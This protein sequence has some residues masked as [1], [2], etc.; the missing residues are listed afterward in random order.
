MERCHTPKT[1]DPKSLTRADMAFILCTLGFVVVPI[2]PGTKRPA[3]KWRSGQGGRLLSRR[4]V[5]R[6][7]RKHPDH[8]VAIVVGSRLIMLDAD[9]PEAEARLHEIEEAHD[10]E[11]NL[12]IRTARGVHHYLRL[13]KG[14]VATMDG[15]DSKTNP[16]AIDI[17]TGESLAI[18]PPSTGKSFE[19][20]EALSVE[21]LP[22]ASQAF[23][24]A[25]ERNNRPPPPLVPTPPPPKQTLPHITFPG[26]NL[27]LIASQ[28]AALDPD[29]GY[30]DWIK[31]GMAIH[32]ETQ[33]SAE[34]LQLFNDWSARGTKYR[35]WA[36]IEEKWGYM[37]TNRNEPITLGTLIFMAQAAD[38][39]LA[40]PAPVVKHGS[41]SPK[42]HALLP[43]SLR[44][45]SAE[46]KD[47]LQEDHFV[48]P[49]LALGGQ[50][51]V[52]WAPPNTG[53][54][55]L[56]LYLLIEA[57]KAGDVNAE[58]LFYINADDNFRGLQEKLEIAEEHGFHMLAPGHE[59]FTAS[60]LPTLFREMAAS[61]HA[62]GTVIALDT[63]KKFVD[64]M[65]KKQCATWGAAARLFI[66]RGG[67][68]ITLAH[69]NKNRN[70]DGRA[71]QG[72]VSDILDDADCGYILDFANMEGDLCTV[73]FENKKARGAVDPE[74]S[75]RYSKAYGIG[76]RDL[77]ASIEPVISG[78]ASEFSAQEQK[79]S[80]IVK[81][82]Q[83]TLGA[84]SLARRAVVGP[85]Y[86]D[87]GATR[88]EIERI[89]D[90]HTVGGGGDDLWQ[91]QR[92]KNNARMYSQIP[93]DTPADAADE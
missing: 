35:G 29:L 52:I 38:A 10:I 71:V 72:G 54:T 42:A 8:D 31:V 6:H 27:K 65:D 51:T 60:D 92:G 53:K 76:Y 24:A 68:L 85:V 49:G 3:I 30:N 7:W 13:E 69:V 73:H 5:A 81:S 70:K 39:G 84:R 36:D 32:H 20:L 25:I 56:A 50:W 34:G 16:T 46:F 26:A 82:I 22:A 45:K 63:L 40:L 23:V 91:E 28:L 17:R 87:T 33:G 47:M 78:A 2:I 59:E 41:P 57:I 74:A 88:R 9:T 1:R 18:V 58:T 62:Q 14:V 90:H 67:T 19:L 55:L 12:I 11:P 21:D 77:L 61:G 80:S 86:T 93:P 4:F 37:H 89:L 66:S 48:L 79:E 43:F 15:L 83:D 75:Y 44:G 64:P